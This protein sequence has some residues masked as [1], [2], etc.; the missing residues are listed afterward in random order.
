MLK[1][2]KK[3]FWFIILILSAI[4]LDRF[5]KNYIIHLS[6]SDPAALH[7]GIPII[8]GLLEIT[9]TYNYGVVFGL[10]GNANNTLLLLLNIFMLVIVSIIV[11]RDLWHDRGSLLYFTGFGMIIG[12]AFGN[13]TDRIVYGK[14]LDFIKVYITSEFVWPIFNIADSF[15]TVGII[16]VLSGLIF[17]DRE[18]IQNAPGTD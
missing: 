7:M 3:V 9:I 6:E 8:K 2:K 16:F 15:I 17:F 14:V 11:V 1:N 5:S 13:I 4:L 12:G 10:L 18:K